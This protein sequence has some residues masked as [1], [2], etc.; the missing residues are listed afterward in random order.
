MADPRVERLADVLV[1][2][3]TEVKEKE[4]VLIRGSTL[5]APLIRALYKKVLQ[6]GAY[7][8]L[9]ISLPEMAKTFYDFANDDQL[10]YLSLIDVH[11]AENT[12][13]F[14]TIQS[15]SNTK[16]LTNIDPEKQAVTSLTRRPLRDIVLGK[17]RWAITLFP[18]EAYAQDA[19]MSL[20]EFEDFVYSTTFADKDDPIAEWK[21][22]SSRQERIVD[23]LNRASIIR[24]VGQDT[25]ISMAVKGRRFINSDG[26][27]NMPS[28]EVFTCPMEDST[29]GY[30][31]FS[32]PVCREGKEVEDIRLEFKEGKVIEASARKNEEFLHKMIEMDEGSGYVG[33]LGIG[34]NWGIDKFIKNILFDEKIGGTIHLALGNA[35]PETKGVNKSALHWDMIKD[36]R[37]EGEIYV[38][39]KLFYKDKKFLDL[40]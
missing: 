15:E 28:G 16:T 39:G 35:Y 19:E 26:H 3:S 9:R 7:P 22:L 38:D 37:E 14:I 25:D 11:E 13:V 32:F 29:G 5:A 31:R 34:T 36:L 1:N 4:V 6:A 21:N 24:I 17:N 8:R 30:I 40:P 10:R 23:F 2:Y 12:D 33:E 18:T 20:E 27:Y